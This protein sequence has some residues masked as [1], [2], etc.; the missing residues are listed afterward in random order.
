MNLVINMANLKDEN[1]KQSD[2]IKEDTENF[3]DNQSQLLEDSTLNIPD[4]TNRM[5]NTIN[6]YRKTNKDRLEKSIDKA[7]KYQQQNINTIQSISNNYVE[8]RKNILISYQSVFSKFINNIYNNKSYWNTFIYPQ[9]YT[10]VYNNTNEN[11][12]DNAINT[13][14]RINNCVFGYTEIVNK[15]IEIIQ[16]YYNDSVQKFYSFVNKIEKSYN[17]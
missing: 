2:T 15:S 4:L 11:I 16:K 9:G 5:T 8:L 12:T 10:D 17:Y 13:T 6:E 3:L 14:R 7:N 1:K